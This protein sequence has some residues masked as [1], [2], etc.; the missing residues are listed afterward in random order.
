MVIGQ[1]TSNYHQVR[2]SMAQSTHQSMTQ[3]TQQLFQFHQFHHQYPLTTVIYQFVH[4][5]RRKR[6]L[7]NTGRT[8]HH[9]DQF[10]QVHNIQTHRP[11]MN[12]HALTLKRSRPQQQHHS[13][14]RQQLQITCSRYIS[15]KLINDI[16]RFR[17][18]SL[19]QLW[20]YQLV[21]KIQQIIGDI[22][23]TAQSIHMDMERMQFLFHRERIMQTH[24]HYGY[25]H[26]KMVHRIYNR[27][28]RTY[29]IVRTITI[30]HS[31]RPC[32]M[33]VQLI[34]HQIIY[35]MLHFHIIVSMAY[36]HNTHAMFSHFNFQHFNSKM[37]IPSVIFDRKHFG[38][39][40]IQVIHRLQRWLEIGHLK[41]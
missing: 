38:D 20:T 18:H 36:K 27:G 9:F 33:E 24:R 37:G 30:N 8:I 28:H 12:T 17:R 2:H 34:N 21:T 40:P 11:L 4:C 10:N 3:S 7:L 13:N 14:H 41:T 5:T 1:S 19:H 25:D 31:H 32:L 39:A 23:Q 16:I 22:I 26:Y 29:K 6:L 15:N 35:I